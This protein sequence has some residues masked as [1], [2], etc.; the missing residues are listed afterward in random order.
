MRKVLVGIVALVS[1]AGG[2]AACGK[3]D[4]TT[5]QTPAAQ[6]ASVP[7]ETAEKVQKIADVKPAGTGTTPVGVVEN[8]EKLPKF[9]LVL[10]EGK[11]GFKF[12]SWALS[13]DAKAKID[14]MFDGDKFDVKTA[15]FEIE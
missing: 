5:E 12:R 8:T 6:L 14:E 4:K 2:V 10:N 15:H 11:S 7:V 13:E 3:T 1:A 9:T